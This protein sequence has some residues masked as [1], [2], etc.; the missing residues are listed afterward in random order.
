[1][2]SFRGQ[3]DKEEVAKDGEEATSK[4]GN[5]QES[6]ASWKPNEGNVSTGRVISSVKG[7]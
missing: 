2:A 6:M 3:W 7:C 4:I 5:K 1:M